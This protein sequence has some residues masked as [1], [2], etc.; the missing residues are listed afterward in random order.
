MT[1]VRRG[2]Y[3]V[4]AVAIALIVCL[5]ALFAADLYVHRRIESAAGVNVWGYRGPVVGRKPPNE[6]RIVVLGGSTA[7]GYGLPYTE[8]FPFFLEQR[9]NQTAVGGSRY[10][11]IN[12]GG[13]SQGAYAFRFDLADYT[14]LRYDAAIL[15]E[16]YNDLGVRDLPPL[17]PRRDGPNYLLWRRQSP[18]FRMTGYFPVLPLA[19][20]EKALLMLSGGD[21]NGAY[22]G[23]VTFQPGLARRTT[24]AALERAADIAERVG[25]EYGSFSGGEPAR[26]PFDAE[27]NIDLVSWRHYTA[28]V[29]SAVRFARDHGAKALVVGQPYASKTHVAQQRALADTLAA[30]FAGDA[31]VRYVDLGTVVDLRDRSIAYDGLHLVAGG[32]DRIASYLVAPVRALLAKEESSQ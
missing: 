16:G 28:S 20:R 22:G 15:Y 11:V 21:L 7:F 27:E 5:G 12:L 23:R 10:R 24:A 29:A 30:R 25:F 2:V 4:I 6:I 14:F 13:L 19:L 18:L 3:I 8:A 26:L 17:V 1:V 32:N 9:L 31:G